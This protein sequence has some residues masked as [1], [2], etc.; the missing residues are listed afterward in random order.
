V[1]GVISPLLLNIAL[2]G[3]EEAAGCRYSPEGHAQREAPILIRYADDFVVLCRTAEEAYEV[4]S[5][6]A[7]WLEP[8]GLAFN[9]EKSSVRSLYEGYDFL[10]FTIR[11]YV[12][13]KRGNERTLVTPSKD[14]VARAKRRVKLS[15]MKYR[16]MPAASLIGALN[17]YTRGWSNY[18]RGASSS[19]TYANLDWYL[20]RCLFKWG[21]RMHP[22]KTKGWIWRRYFGE[23]RFR[24]PKTG[25]LLVPFYT[26]ITR[27]VAIK[28]KA[29]PDDPSLK[30]YWRQRNAKKKPPRMTARKSYL[31]ARQKGL[32]ALC[33][34]VLIV[35]AEYEPDNVRDWVQWFEAMR[36]SLHADHLVY[37]RDGGSDD[38]KNL[39]LVH[40]DC[41]RLHHAG[42]GRRS[43]PAT[44]AA[45]PSWSA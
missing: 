19:R 29:S 45:D 8:R 9:E 7:K 21:M 5:K 34:Q 36:H 10:G 43:R 38:V 1:G 22:R 35:G 23:N 32:C 2:N 26:E 28:G 15:V 42:D 14:S 13:S 44:T 16:G 40:A 24:D 20:K 17:P 6:L 39:R 33:R 27:H 31:A 41:H 37:R 11:R 18:Y 25:N 4:K 30:T 12:A 3:M